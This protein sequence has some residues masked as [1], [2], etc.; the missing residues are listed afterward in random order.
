MRRTLACDTPTTPA[1]DQLCGCAMLQETG[2]ALTQC[3]TRLDVTGLTQ[4][5]CYADPE[6]APGSPI[7]SHCVPSQQRVLRIVNPTPSNVFLACSSATK[8]IETRREA[9]GVHG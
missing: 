4:G 8:N 7:Y 1:C 5:F 6:H 9:G 2:D 3:Q